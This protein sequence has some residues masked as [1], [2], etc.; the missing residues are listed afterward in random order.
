MTALIG[1]GVLM[2]FFAIYVAKRAGQTA[3]DAAALG[4][5]QAAEQAFN[6]VARS[7]LE[8]RLA[9]LHRTASDEISRRLSDWEAWRRAVLRRELEAIEPPWPLEEIEREISL[10]ISQEW[11]GV[12]HAIREDVY[13]S[14]VRDLSVAQAL[15]D[16]RPV[17]MVA[18]LGEFFSAV[19]RGCMIRQAGSEQASVIRATADWF[20][21]QNGAAG[22]MDVTF[23]YDGQIKVRAVALFPVPFGLVA[24]F[25][26]RQ[27][28]PVEAT[29][30]A[31]KPAGLTFDLTGSC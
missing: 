30:R 14:L 22:A 7:A 25:V 19:E 4:A 9:A 18:G 24:R 10:V 15:L 11:S 5:L 1:I 21:V 3:A 2:D 17:P 28:L 6:Q 26:P 29:S 31:I 16:G 23:P 8:Q 12:Y 20:A 13:R 27:Y